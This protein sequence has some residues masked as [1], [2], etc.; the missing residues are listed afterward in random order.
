[1]TAINHDGPLLDAHTLVVASTSR[2]D[3][4]LRSEGSLTTL[5]TGS[6]YIQNIRVEAQIVCMPRHL[7]VVALDFEGFEVVY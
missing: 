6:T 3:L 1:M 7:L 2:L 4:R 5:L